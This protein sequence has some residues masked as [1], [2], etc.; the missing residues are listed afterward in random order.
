MSS[1]RTVE[2]FLAA[3][4]ESLE[5]GWTLEE[6]ARQCGLGRS[7]FAHYCWEITN[8]SPAEYLVHCRVQAAKKLLT[9]RPPRSITDVALSC[10]FNSSQ[11]FAT[12][13]RQKTGQTPRAFRRDSQ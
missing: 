2:L 11:Y 5:H 12:L 1:R 6:M 8:F 3:L 10:G 13:F 7:R 4:P 9:S